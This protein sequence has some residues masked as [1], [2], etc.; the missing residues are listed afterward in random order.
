MVRRLL[1][2]ILVSK[3]GNIKSPLYFCDYRITWC[4][5]NTVAMKTNSVS[6]QDITRAC[7]LGGLK[8]GPNPGNVNLARMHM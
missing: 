7:L 3:R 5:K 6:L 1:S 2:C 8:P 4:G